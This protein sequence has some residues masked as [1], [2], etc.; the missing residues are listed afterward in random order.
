[1]SKAFLAFFFVF[2]GIYASAQT[3]VVPAGLTIT[4]WNFNEGSTQGFVGGG[5]GRGLVTTIADGG[6]SLESN[7]ILT[8]N[9]NPNCTVDCSKTETTLKIIGSQLVGARSVNQ[10]FGTQANPVISKISSSGIFGGSL[11]ITWVATPAPAVSP[12]PP[13]PATP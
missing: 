8:S 2:F 1:M 4:G 12:T 10:G 3:V 13:A 11:G 5:D 7:S 9:S 6:M